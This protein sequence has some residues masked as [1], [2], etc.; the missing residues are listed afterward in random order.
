MKRVL[1]LRLDCNGIATDSRVIAFRMLA[2]SPT[3]STLTAARLEVE[4]PIVPALRPLAPRAA[5]D[6][7]KAVVA[8][9]GV[10]GHARPFVSAYRFSSEPSKAGHTLAPLTGCVI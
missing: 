8:V 7:P 5:A 10:R 4:V 2:C 9:S 1:N 6:L 3:H